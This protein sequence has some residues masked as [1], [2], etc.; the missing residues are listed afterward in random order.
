MHCRPS[1]DGRQSEVSRDAAEA[2]GFRDAVV[3]SRLIHNVLRCTLHERADVS[4]HGS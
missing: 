2:A 1:C 3:R 4:G